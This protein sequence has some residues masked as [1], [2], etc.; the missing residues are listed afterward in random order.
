ILELA[1]H[2]IE[3]AAD[4]DVTKGIDYAVSAA[5]QLFDHLAFSDARRWYRTASRLL[6]SSSVRDEA[7][8]LDLLIAQR[9]TEALAGRDSAL[10][11]LTRAADLALRLGDS[12]ALLQAALAVRVEPMF[13]PPASGDQYLRMLQNAVEVVPSNDRSTRARLL[14]LAAFE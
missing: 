8:R 5:R 9:Q 7:R 10:Q 14:A 3:A 13:T 11:T 4:G 6:E 1:H 12:A 2:Y